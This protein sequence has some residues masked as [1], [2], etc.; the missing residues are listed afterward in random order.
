L[1]KCDW[2]YFQKDNPSRS[3]SPSARR[4]YLQPGWFGYVSNLTVKVTASAPLVDNNGKGYHATFKK[5]GKL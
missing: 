5:N 2:S 1:H 4:D 3:G